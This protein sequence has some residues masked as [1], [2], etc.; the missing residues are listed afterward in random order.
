MS[1]NVQNAGLLAGDEI[2]QVNVSDVVATVTWAGEVAPG[3]R[4]RLL[5]PAEKEDGDGHPGPW[6][7]SSSSWTPTAARVVEPGKLMSSLAPSSR[8]AQPPAATLRVE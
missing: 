6:E 2:V 8:D 5:A 7:D 3:L 4:A 1:V